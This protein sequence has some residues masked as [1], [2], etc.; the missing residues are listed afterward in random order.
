[1]AR[2]CADC[3]PTSAVYQADIVKR[4]ILDQTT[5]DVK[6]NTTLDGA[7]KDH[8]ITIR[9]GTTVHLKRKEK[10]FEEINLQ[11]KHRE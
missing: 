1:M 9:Q 8:S 11:V 5:Y 7:S 2:L 4:V 10:C 3:I 6:Q